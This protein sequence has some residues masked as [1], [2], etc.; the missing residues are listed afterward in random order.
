MSQQCESERTLAILTTYPTVNKELST[1]QMKQPPP[2]QPVLFYSGSGKCVTAARLKPTAPL[3][4]NDLHGKQNLE[5]H[6]CSN[7]LH[8]PARHF[9]VCRGVS[10]LVVTHTRYSNP[11]HSF[12]PTMKVDDCTITA[13]P[14]AEL[15]LTA[16]ARELAELNRKTQ[17]PTI[18]A[19]TF[20]APPYLAVLRTNVERWISVQEDRDKTAP[21]FV[22]V[23]IKPSPLFINSQSVTVSDEPVL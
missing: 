22:V 5:H 8:R 15:A 11:T 3:L 4:K 23:S 12:V 16:P 1:S 18:P 20:T 13:G 17:F 14:A 2:I 9:P 19:P 7:P 6:M 21:P 10:L